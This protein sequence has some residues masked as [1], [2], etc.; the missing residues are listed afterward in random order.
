MYMYQKPKQYR[1]L[2]FAF[3]FML[4]GI[5]GISIARLYTPFESD[6]VLPVIEEESDFVISLPDEQEI[7]ILP[8]DV[9]A[10]VVL[11]YYDGSEHEVNDFTNFEGVYRTNQGI[12]YAC[13]EESFEVKAMASGT[14]TQVKNDEIFGNTISITSGQLVITYQ[15]IDALNFSEGDE[16]TQGTLIGC[17]SNNTYNP[18]LGNHLHIVTT[19]S[20]SLVNP[21]DVI[22]KSLKEFK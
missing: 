21:K 13:N 8:Y 10:V 22:N 19:V 1:R 6:I 15:S 4:I 2:W 5:L 3:V 7:V 11:E 14:I 16:I 17:A 12:D 20:G 9:E 18:E